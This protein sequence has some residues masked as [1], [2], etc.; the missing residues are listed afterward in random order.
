MEFSGIEVGVCTVL[1]IYLSRALCLWG[2]QRY[3]GKFW[4]VFFL[5]GALF[6]GGAL[7]LTR[8]IIPVVLNVAGFCCLWGVGECITLRRRKD[9]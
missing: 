1:S 9:G 6:L 5:L 4:W 2:V 3:G 7:F 8:G